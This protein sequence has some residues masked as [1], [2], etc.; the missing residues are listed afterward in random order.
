MPKRPGKQ[1]LKVFNNFDVKRNCNTKTELE[2][3]ICKLDKKSKLKEK[4]VPINDSKT[5]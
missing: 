4:L 1:W 5:H 2:F 3:K